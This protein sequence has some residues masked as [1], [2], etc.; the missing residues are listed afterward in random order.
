MT[1]E[2]DFV[3]VLVATVVGMAI[4]FVYFLPGVFGNAWMRAI[5]KTKEQLQGGA[6]QLLYGFSQGAASALM[7]V[8]EAALLGASGAPS[9]M[10]G[11]VLGFILWIGVVLPVVAITFLFEGRGARNIGLTSGYH[12]LLLVVMGGIIGG[13]PW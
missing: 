13:W 1:W 4:G 10:R 3:T 5:G 6:N 2:I 8:V 12:L 9:L 11:I 7:A